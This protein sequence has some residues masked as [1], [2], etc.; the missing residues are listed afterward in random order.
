MGK[1]RETAPKFA[2]GRIIN[3][4]LECQME[5]PAKPE[6]AEGA[7]PRATVA[8]LAELGGHFEMRSAMLLLLLVLGASAQSAGGLRWTAPSGWTSEGPTP[9]RAATYK[10][11]P[12]PGDADTAECSVYF[13][14]AGQGGDVQANIDRWAEQF[15]ASGGK[16]STPRVAKKTIQGLSVTTV[17]VSGEYTG[18]AAEPMAGVAPPKPGYRMLG[19]I[20]ENSGAS[21]FLRFTGQQKTIAANQTKF[22]Q[23]LKSFEKE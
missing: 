3:T 13:F 9:M 16:P 7:E 4:G 1:M 14:G 12:A 5:M 19:A 23:L 17:D 6:S 20:I 8:R 10:I 15:K 21:V 11:P 18:M 22:E 2:V